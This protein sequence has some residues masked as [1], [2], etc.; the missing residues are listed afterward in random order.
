MSKEVALQRFPENRLHIEQA[1]AH[2]HPQAP[3]KAKRQPVTRSGYKTRKEYRF[4][5]KKERRAA[6]KK[7]WIVF[8]FVA[9]WLIAFRLATGSWG[10]AALLVVALYVVV[11][12]V[13]LAK[14]KGQ[15]QGDQFWRTLW[16]E[17]K[18]GS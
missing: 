1:E 3:K 13:V 5:K 7:V 18:S 16:T 8:A 9:P 6:E 12:L 10:T 17:L 15:Y 14:A 4:A 11:A 2:W